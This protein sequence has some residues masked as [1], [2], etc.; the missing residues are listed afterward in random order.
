MD[1]NHERELLLTRRHF[2]GRTAAGIGTAALASLLNPR[3]FAGP[4]STAPSAA[5]GILRALHH[6]PRAKRVIYLFMSGGP[7]H[8][9]LFDYKPK[10]SAHHGQELP[11]TVRMGQRITGM[12]SGQ[13]SFPCVAPMFKFS[14]HGQ[15]GT[16]FSELL[17]HT[18]TIADEI[19]V[20]KSMN[21]EAINHDPAITY[22][23]TGSQ[24]PGRPSMG[25]WLSYGLVS[26]NQNLPAYVV[27]ISLASNG[28]NDQ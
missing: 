12:T 28:A 24:Q 17:P 23:Q 14:Q 21:T 22:I 6:A 26:E 3:L 15:C 9:D 13:K 20:I 4:A 8:I 11:A 18:A 27:M 5:E 2:F 19:C 16:W 7:S 10:L 25:A 1:L